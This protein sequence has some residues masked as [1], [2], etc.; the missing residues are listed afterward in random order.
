MTIGVHDFEIPHDRVSPCRDIV[1]VRVPR[2]PRKVGSIIVPGMS[3]DMAQHNTMAGII[4]SMG[5]MAF[6]EK[7][8][9]HD[10]RKVQVWM[11]AARTQWRSPE[12]GDWAVF[13]PFAGTM[14]A[15]GKLVASFG[16]RYLS[17]FGDVMGVV[18]PKF[19]PAASDLLW[20]DEDDGHDQAAMN[21]PTATGEGTVK[22]VAEELPPGVR[23][24][25]VY[26]KEETRG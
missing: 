5:A 3:R 19:M 21:F 12:V 20:D 18:D 23:E 13:R 6:A 22:P 25:T 4:T 7:H 1:I 16:Y 8:A 17:S 9:D 24:R 15:G 2:P 11:D 10:Y 14:V 26:P